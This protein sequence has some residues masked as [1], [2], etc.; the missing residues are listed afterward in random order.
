[1]YKKI[2]AE[3]LFFAILIFSTAASAEIQTFEGVGTY[4]MENENET[5]DFAK[6]KAKL[7]AELNALEQ[8]QVY[9]YSYSEL[10]NL[11]LKQDEIIS[12][13]AGILKVTDI[14]YSLKTESDILLMCATVTAEIDTDKISEMVE[15]EIKRHTEEN[16]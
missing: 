8:A 5:L 12:I 6:N 3:I 10:H 1:M 2:S 9:I 7:A 4:Y 16:K 15:H 11:N 13:T 14:R